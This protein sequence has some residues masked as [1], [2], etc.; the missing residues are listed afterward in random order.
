MATAYVNNFGGGVRLFYGNYTFT[1]CQINGNSAYYGGGLYHENG[2]TAL[3]DTTF[4]DNTAV[5]GAGI[6]QIGGALNMTDQCI[7]GGNTAS[8]G[9]G[10]LYV[11]YGVSTQISEATFYDNVAAAGAGI[12]CNGQAMTLYRCHL[13][14]NHSSSAGS[15][16]YFTNG[17]LTLMDNLIHGNTTGTTGSALYC[18]NV[19]DGRIHHNTIIGNRSD[20]TG[21]ALVGDLNSTLG[22]RHNI[23]AFNTGYGIDLLYTDETVEWN[24]LYGNSS[25]NYHNWAWPGT[26]DVSADPCFVLNGFWSDPCVTPAD[27]DDDLWHSGDYRLREYSACIHTGDPAF[28]IDPTYPTDYDGTDRIVYGRVDIGAIEAVNLCPG[29]FN[30][31]GI[32]NIMDRNG[33]LS[34]WLTDSSMTGFDAIYDLTADD[35]V[36]LEDWA[37]FSKHWNWLAPWLGTASP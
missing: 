9:G 5:N 17:T 4:C 2:T 31:D 34:H 8:T 1:D 29:D 26:G 37:I 21:G 7:L 18:S 10:G 3:I 27:P 11:N 14:T 13:K 35:M 23:V 32:V 24:N 28:T 33:F 20:C 22:I 25:G 6:Y 19:D 30:N 12:Y 36:D 16:V 15:A